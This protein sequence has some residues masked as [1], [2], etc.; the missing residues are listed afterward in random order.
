MKKKAME[1][2][3]ETQKRKSSETTG[4]S[5]TPAKKK[6]RRSGSETMIYLKEKNERMLEM[7]NRKLELQEQNMEE[8]NIWVINGFVPKGARPSY[9]PKS[10]LYVPKMFQN[11]SIYGT[12]YLMLFQYITILITV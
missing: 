7:E 11:Y 2:L 3:G 9:L 10:G 8:A 6:T 5:S 12:V 1:S 4:S